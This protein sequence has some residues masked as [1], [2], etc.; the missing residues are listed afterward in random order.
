MKLKTVVAAA[1]VAMPAVVRAQ[2]PDTLSLDGRNAL[3][4]GLGLTSK[5]SASASLNGA[6]SSASGQ[7]G[8]LEFSHWFRPIVAFQVSASVL[9][10]EAAST[11]GQVHDNTLTPILAGFS[12]SPRSFALSRNARPYLSA[13]VGP[14]IHS[15]S[16][17]VGS[18]TSNTVETSFGARFGAGLNWF[19][20]R[21]FLLGVDVNYHA[22]GKFD[23]PDAITK[24]PSGFG[25]SV[26]IGFAWGGR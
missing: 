15:V 6:S 13:Q 3:A 5:S 4:L 1:L 17:V 22:V 14:Y 7:I 11:P 23:H 21:H 18:S 24:N 8:S 16:D 2:S 20:A 19:I 9:G 26:L 10:A 12:V 25:A